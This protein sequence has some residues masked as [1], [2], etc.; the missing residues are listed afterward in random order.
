[1][2]IFILI[3]WLANIIVFTFI[4]LYSFRIIKHNLKNKDKTIIGITP[5]CNPSLNDTSLIE[6]DPTINNTL[7]KTKRCENGN[8][9]ITKTD[10]LGSD[11]LYQVNTKIKY[12]IQACKTACMDT[13][14]NGNCKDIKNQDEYDY[15]VKLIEPQGC[16]ATSTP[17]AKKG[18][19]FYYL[20]SVGD[21]DCIYIN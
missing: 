9:V 4:S 14:T 15:C 21:D 12:Y 6:I 11:H 5:D 1:M 17:I 10:T 8:L 18:T 2:N 16:K 3:I 13:D 7:I 20:W 19:E